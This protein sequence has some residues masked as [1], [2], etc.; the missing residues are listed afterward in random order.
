MKYIKIFVSVLLSFIFIVRSHAEQGDFPGHAGPYLG[1][2][3][4]VAA[5]RRAFAGDSALNSVV[6]KIEEIAEAEAR[7][8]LFSGTVLVAASGRILY[9]KG[10][11]EANREHH[12][13]N[14]LNTRFNIG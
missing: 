12:V 4:P 10:F 3:S 9:A 13:P 6:G 8:R 14:G 2:P 5:E 7:F 11:S 1:Q